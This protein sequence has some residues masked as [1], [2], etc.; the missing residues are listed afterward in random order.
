MVRKILI[1]GS[2]GYLGSALCERLPS[3]ALLEIRGLDRGHT[4]EELR[5]SLQWCDVCILANGLSNH[6]AGQENP[7]LDFQLNVAEILDIL[8]SEKG[9][10]FI[11]LGSLC[12]YGVLEGKIEESRVCD[13]KEPQGLSKVFMEGA[14]GFLQKVNHLDF[15][16]LR[17][18]TVFGRKTDLNNPSLLEKM[19]L[20][21]LHGKTFEVYGGKE[22]TWSG[23]SI[24][25]FVGAIAKVIQKDKYEGRVYNLATCQ[26]P[27]GELDQD[28][29]LKFVPSNPATPYAV[30]CQRF[31][32]QFGWGFDSLNARDIVRRLKIEIRQFQSI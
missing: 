14:L 13:P 4:E 30:S 1:I 10:K 2:K 7:F 32:D 15:V 3:E 20:S 8:K 24:E 21:T 16:S 23:L 26:W 28:L 19:I 12:Q 17:L 29:S 22:R 27:F 11:Y 18:G 25:H 6:I 9:L 5:K 31:K